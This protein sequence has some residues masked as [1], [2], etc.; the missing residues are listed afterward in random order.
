M[1]EAFREEFGNRPGR[2][3]WTEWRWDTTM[4]VYGPGTE[5]DYLEG[6]CPAT[7]KDQVACISFDE[8]SFKLYVYDRF[9]PVLGVKDELVFDFAQPDGI[10]RIIEAVVAIVEHHAIL[11]EVTKD[12]YISFSLEMRKAGKIV[13]DIDDLP[14]EHRDIYY[15]HN[16]RWDF[17]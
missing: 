10:D 16:D 12:E 3:Y 7:S 11:R 17:D 9:E 5:L 14:P 13:P 4:F 2:P 15:R 1:A 6:G 8:S